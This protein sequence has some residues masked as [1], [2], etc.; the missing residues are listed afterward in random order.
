MRRDINHAALKK[1]KQISQQELNAIEISQRTYREHTL[2]PRQVATNMF[3]EGKSFR[4]IKERLHVVDSKIILEWLKEEFS[5][6]EIRKF[7][8]NDLIED[9][10]KKF[11]EQTIKKCK[12]IGMP[13]NQIIEYIANRDFIK[14]NTNLKSKDELEEYIKK[15]IDEEEKQ[16]LKA[17]ER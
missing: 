16:Q 2:G 1:M 17:E 4:E 3:K 5:S 14:E 8:K 15:I 10:T 12:D 13:K 7:V 9:I 11:V 6:E